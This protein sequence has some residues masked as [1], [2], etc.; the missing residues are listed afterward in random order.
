[1]RAGGAG[2]GR[3]AGRGGGGGAFAPVGEYQV[4]L[5]AAGEH[6]TKTA[7]IRERIR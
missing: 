7:R 6:L 4:A 5:D 1:M 2:G 3:G